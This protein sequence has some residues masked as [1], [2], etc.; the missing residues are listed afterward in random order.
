MAIANPNTAVEGRINENP[1][2]GREGTYR[3]GDRTI[4]GDR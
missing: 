1:S 2:K 3:F 4:T